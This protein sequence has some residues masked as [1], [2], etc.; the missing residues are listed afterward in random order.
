[1]SLRCLISILLFLL[2][3]GYAA[4]SRSFSP[5]AFDRANGSYEREKYEE[6][7]ALYEKILTND[8]DNPKVHYNLADTYFR[9]GRFEEAEKHFLWAL[10][11]KD[12]S[13]REFSLYNLGNTKY[14]QQKLE[15]SIAYYDKVLEM[16]PDNE[17]AA[18]NREFV[19]KLLEKKEKET[20]KEQ[21]SQQN[22]QQQG[23]QQEQ[24]QSEAQ[25]K[26][27]WSGESGSPDKN[28]A[29]KQEEDQKQEQPKAVAP[30]VPEEKS[31]EQKEAVAKDQPM[32]N[33]GEKSLSKEEAEFWLGAIQDDPKKAA[34]DMMKREVPAERARVEKDW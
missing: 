30:P 1:M 12:S 14:R 9:L 10:N 31:P 7:R 4:P 3:I 8:P 18:A 33:A 15:D 28:Q 27:D 2:L 29:Q 25:S 20:S 11:A 26:A 23:Q 32:Y 24:Q 22:Q 34:Q 19:K 5:F 16:N 17:K 6:A 21:Q 13:I